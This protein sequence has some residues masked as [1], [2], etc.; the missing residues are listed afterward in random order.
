MFARDYN[1]I[2]NEILTA[3]RNMGPVESLDLESL[4]NELPDVYNNYLR[5]GEPDTSV[6][7]VLYMDGSVLASMVYGIYK[8][9]DKIVD[10]F[11]S[12]TA[13]RKNLERQAAD[14]GL[15][16]TGM[17]D[18]QLRAALG[19]IKKLRLMGGNRFDYD[20]WARSCRVGDELVVSTLVR[21]LAQGEGT[22][23]IVITGNKNNGVPSE[24]LLNAVVAVIERNRTV[25]SGFSWGLRIVGAVLVNQDV[26][27]TDDTPGFDR[28]GAAGDI[29]AYI[30]SLRPGQPLFRS[31]LSSICIQLGATNPII[32]TPST[33]VV[34]GVDI[35]SGVYSKLWP[36]DIE[37]L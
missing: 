17:T 7:S 31:Q 6:G 13:E 37:V 16:S 11:F 10:Q 34:P 28:D 26:S 8:T 21:P 9:A 33:D 20:V 36:G 3:Y 23:D 35:L 5:Q 12:D 14:F 4:K 18:A 32:S 15:I 25:A 19:E 27:I 30:K 24:E 22:F 29:A 1:D 2:L